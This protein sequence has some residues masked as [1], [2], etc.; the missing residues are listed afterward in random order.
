MGRG[1]TGGPAG[2]GQA[3]P[4]RACPPPPAHGTLLRGGTI[5]ATFVIWV[6]VA[7]AEAACWGATVVVEKRVLTHVTPLGTNLLVRVVSLTC[8]VALTVPLT[9]LHLWRLTF[10]VT[11]SSFVYVTLSAVVTWLIAFNTYYAALSIGR[12]SIVAPLTAID[13]LFAALFAALLIGAAFGGLTVVGLLVATLGVVL[14]SRWMG[15]DEPPPLTAEL[16]AA[17]TPGVSPQARAGDLEV[18]LLSL[19]TAAGWGVSPVLIQL[20]QQSTGGATTTMILQ[21]Q[22]IGLALLAAIVLGRRARV[23]VRP[24]AY[25]DRRHVALLVVVAGI[26]EATFSVLY[27]LVIEQIGAVLTVLI[28]STTPIFAILLG[29]VVLRERFGRRLALASVITLLGVLLATL[30]RL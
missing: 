30:D 16:V 1:A 10:A 28:G 11:W 17:P 21:S 25:P 9:V 14:I 27:Y 2:D 29:V 26:L 8:L 7:F 5:S 12:V 15:G 22:A 6:G 3:R 4:P 23:W 13:P 20:A 18:I 19:V 24:I